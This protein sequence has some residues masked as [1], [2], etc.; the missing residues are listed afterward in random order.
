M[1]M[2]WGPS[3]NI[4]HVLDDPQDFQCMDVPDVYP[5]LM[6]CYFMNLQIIIQIILTESFCL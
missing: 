3:V 6:L 2:P 4:K 5:K 1:E